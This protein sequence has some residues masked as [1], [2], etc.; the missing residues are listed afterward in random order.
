MQVATRK[1]VLATGTASH[2]ARYRIVLD[3]CSVL[4]TLEVLVPYGWYR[5]ARCTS[6]VQC[7]QYALHDEQYPWGMP[8]RLLASVV[9][10][11]CR[12]YPKR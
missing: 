8:P 5:V 6:I 2:G 12:A 10:R 1:I 4:P 9:W 3:A 11:A 7:K